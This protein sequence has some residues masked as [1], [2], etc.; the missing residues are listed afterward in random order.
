MTALTPLTTYYVRAFA[1]NSAGTAFGNELSFTT[2]SGGLAIGQPYQGGIIAY[3]FQSGDPG[4]IGGETHGLIAAPS[5]QSTG[6]QWYNGSYITTGAIDT[7]LGKGMSNTDT[8]VVHQGVGS[9]A[10]R[11]CSDLL[12]GGYTDWYLPS[13]EELSLVYLSRGAIGGFIV[14]GYWSSSEY[15]SVSAWH[16]DFS[17]GNPN[18]AFGKEAM[19]RV[20]AVRKF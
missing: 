1:T 19:L 11:L 18:P 6:I 10:A 16:I 17:N 15:S 9:Y 14:F 13:R 5:D 12:F 7:A 8:I 2:L 20:R 3:I 4:Y